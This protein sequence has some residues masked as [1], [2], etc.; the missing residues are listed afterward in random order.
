MLLRKI[1]WNSISLAVH[2][3]VIRQL[4]SLGLYCNSDAYELERRTAQWFLSEYSRTASVTSLLSTL[5]ILKLQLHRQSSR[6]T[7]SILKN[8]QQFTY[9]LSLFLHSISE[10]S[11]TQGSTIRITLF[12][13]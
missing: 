12:C 9:Y 8:N 5:E 10:P 2:S 7:L 1:C 6:L 3:N 11:S 4:R 13:P